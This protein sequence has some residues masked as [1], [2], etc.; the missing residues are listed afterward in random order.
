MA[1]RAPTF[2]VIVAWPSWTGVTMPSTTVAILGSL[3]DHS[4]PLDALTADFAVLDLLH[5]QR[6]PA[7]RGAE[8]AFRREQDHAVGPT[9]PQPPSA[10]ARSR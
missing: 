5:D 2:A 9:R 7:L 1:V 4:I 3:D 10:Q 6:L 8:R